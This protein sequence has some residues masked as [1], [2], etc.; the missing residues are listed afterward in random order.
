MAGRN[1]VPDAVA[2]RAAIVPSVSH[3]PKSSFRRPKS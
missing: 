3:I 1:K 2:A